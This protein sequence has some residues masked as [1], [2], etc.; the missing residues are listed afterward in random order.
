MKENLLK[1]YRFSNSW[2][3][4]IIIVLMIIFFGIQ[5]FVIP[6][7]SMI[8]TLLIGDHLFVKKYVYGIP[9]PHVPF[10]EIPLI[11][12]KS[13][14]II[15]GN[16][17]KKGDIVVFRYPLNQKLHFVKRCVAVGGD[18]VMMHNKILY[19]H[20][21]GGDEEIKKD[22]NG[23]ETTSIGGKLWLKAPYQ[24]EHP[25]VHYDQAAISDFDQFGE[26]KDELKDPNIFYENHKNEEIV[27]DGSF[28]M[29]SDN[30]REQ[31]KYYFGPYIVPDD[32]FFMMGDNRDNSADSRFWGPATYAQVVGTPWFVYF[33]WDENYLIKWDRIGKSVSSLEETLLPIKQP[34]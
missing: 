27:F 25:G 24:K 1:L 17:P 4:T 2:T 14:H 28:S 32:C 21:K 5:A 19:I 3:G 15:D 12:T 30:E 16:R 6:S 26:L 18:E 31:R 29:M 22:F 13:G 11:K 7:G 34:K 8:N 23:F 33:S 20:P 10:L 9:D